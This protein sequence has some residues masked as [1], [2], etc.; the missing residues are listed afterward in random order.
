MTCPICGGDTKVR[1]TMSNVDNN[2]RQRQCRICGYRFTTE[3]VEN[4]NISALLFK[5]HN[6]R[7]KKRRN[8][9][10]V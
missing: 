6:E 7:R 5:I 2:L 3:E 10:E 9:N 1:I 8:K 4:P